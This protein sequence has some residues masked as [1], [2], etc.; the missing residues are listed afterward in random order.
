[1]PSRVR[2]LSRSA[3]NSSFGGESVQFPVQLFPFGPQAVRVQRAPEPIGVALR[4]WKPARP[5]GGQRRLDVEQALP[6]LRFPLGDYAQPGVDGRLNVVR[7]GIGRVLAGVAGR[8][9]LGGDGRIAESVR[10][11]GRRRPVGRGSARAAEIG[12][13]E[14]GRRAVL[15]PARRDAGAVSPRG[16][17]ERRLILLNGRRGS[18]APGRRDQEPEGESRRL[19]S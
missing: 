3:K 12:V 17:R 11:Q 14:A 8:K 9:V 2:G 19:R 13:G 18:G 5:D 6:D 1:M 7:T 10:L 15:L 4:G 16:L